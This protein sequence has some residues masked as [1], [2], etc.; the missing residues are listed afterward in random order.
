MGLLKLV[1]WGIFFVLLVSGCDDVK[2]AVGVM[3]IWR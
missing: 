2:Y 1:C 3:V